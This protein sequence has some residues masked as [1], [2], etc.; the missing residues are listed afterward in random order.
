MGTKQITVEVAEATHETLTAVKNLATDIQTA[1]A[2][3]WQPAIDTITIL[4]SAVLNVAKAVQNMNQ[5]PAEAK[6]TKEFVHS[7]TIGGVEIGFV[8]VKPA[9]PE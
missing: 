6:L 8:F 9:Q 7:V 1:L 2:D 5:I 4:N 3:G